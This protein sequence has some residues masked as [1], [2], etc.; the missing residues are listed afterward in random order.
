MT[1]HDSYVM[2]QVRRQDLPDGKLL[3]R[4][5]LPLGPVAKNTGEWLHRWANEAPNR[6]F[7][8]ERSGPGWREISYAETLQQVQSLAS[9]MLARGMGPGTPIVVLSG[10]GIDHGVL[11][12]AAQYIGVPIAPLAEQYSL[13]PEARPRLVHCVNKIKPAM[14]FAE[15]GEA[16]GNA[17]Q[18]DI[19]DDVEKVVSRNV[20]ADATSFDQMLKIKLSGALAQ[21]AEC[22]DP[23]TLAKILFTSGSTGHPKGVPQTQRMVTVNQAQYLA[24]MPMFGARPPVIVEW[25]P[26]NHVFAGNSDFYLILSNGGT[27]I[28]DDGKPVKGLFDRTLE[29][30]SM[31]VGTMSFNVPIAYSMLVDAFRKDNR[32]KQRFFADLDL[33]FYA[34]ASLPADLWSALEDMSRE[35]T[36]KVPMMTSSWGLTE[37]APSC[38]I[39]HQGGAES[40]M[41]GVPVPELDVKLIPYQ[42]NRY[43]IRVRGPN[44]ITSYFDEPDKDAEAFDEEGYFIT[45]DAVRFVDPDDMAAGV[46]FDGRITEDF[47]LMTGTWVQ[48]ARIRLQVLATLEGLVQDVVVTG[49]DREQIGLLIFASPQHIHADSSDSVI[50]DS[51]YCEQ[52]KQALQPMTN[53]ATG[54]STRITRFL[55]MAQP[56]SVKDGEITAK[57]SLNISA[58]L[59]C[60][61]D[62]LT[63]LYDDDGATI[64]L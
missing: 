17:L 24:C 16:F 12:L 8:M 2:H 40:G 32:L 36:G 10:A 22:V 61:S 7:L 53:S 37:T 29:N 44:V 38:L 30:L 1:S 13:I 23:D 26:W 20:P 11:Q 15:N 41:I 62:L 14:V 27:L 58:V 31:H 48:A 6:A 18:L 21:A 64:T 46:R 60:R 39:H 52:I 47:K 55:V 56:P 34:G 63:R 49:A 51:A 42:D 54:S 28:L 19:F 45:N 50:T 59:R 33:I 35:V 57:G 3:L 5:E 4:S 9:A 43:E 25:L